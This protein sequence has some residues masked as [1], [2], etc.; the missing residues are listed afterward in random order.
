[1]IVKLIS[2][3]G[4][5]KLVEGSSVFVRR[6]DNHLDITVEMKREYPEFVPP[7]THYCIR[8]REAR[9]LDEE[10]HFETMW[11]FAFVMEDGKTIDKIEF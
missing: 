11:D 1:M 9:N 4:T 6:M 2:N 10:K 5:Q 3:K 8:G 7:K